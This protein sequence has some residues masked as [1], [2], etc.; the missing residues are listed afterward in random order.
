VHL[1][2]LSEPADIDNHTFRTRRQE[3][4]DIFRCR[5]SIYDDRELTHL[6]TTIDNAV[7]KSGT[8]CGTKCAGSFAVFYAFPWEGHDQSRP[9]I[10]HSI[11]KSH[12]SSGPPSSPCFSPSY[13]LLSTHSDLRETSAGCMLDH[14]NFIQ[15]AGWSSP[16]PSYAIVPPESANSRKWIDYWVKY[17]SSILVPMDISD[18][19]FREV[20]IPMAYSALGTHKDSAGS[21]A[22]LHAICSLGGFNYSN[23]LI[24]TEKQLQRVRALQSHH[25]SL[26]YL[27]QAVAKRDETEKDVVLAS[28]CVLAFSDVFGE[29]REARTWQIHL[30][31]GQQLIHWLQSTRNGI[32]VH[33]SLIYQTFWILSCFGSTR[34]PSTSLKLLQGGYVSESGP[35]IVSTELS[36]D[37]QVL[38]PKENFW[39]LGE[40]HP[41]KHYQLYRLYGVTQPILEC[42]AKINHLQWNHL[43]STKQCISSLRNKILRNNPA[44]LAFPTE[45]RPSASPTNMSANLARAYSHVFFYACLIHFKRNLL[46]C[47]L[48]EVQPFVAISAGYFDEIA[49]LSSAL[50][51]GCLWPLFITAAES[52][53]E[54]QR[55]S[56]LKLLSKGTGLGYSSYANAK[57]LVVE[58]WRRRDG[59]VEGDVRWQDVGI[60]LGI[61]ILLT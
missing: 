31:G 7:Q 15:P 32:G 6:L 10:P 5:Q 12:M 30:H 21:Q 47:P 13:E 35:S 17:M 24:G 18:N 4:P 60:E 61:E 36:L 58:L 16:M 42:I 23:R 44:Y 25:T 56:V 11:H 3:F 52:Q 57:D 33:M 51:T 1:T 41:G 53:S 39:N 43:E 20:V 48:G 14:P 37:S 19:P 9:D 59:M 46:R 8:I 50:E 26:Q 40:A 29:K 34:P 27:A 54:K 38:S 55:T 45:S 28:I 49:Q 2:W 22:M